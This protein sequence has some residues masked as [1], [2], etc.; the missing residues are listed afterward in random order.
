[1]AASQ[2]DQQPPATDD[3]GQDDDRPEWA[4]DLKSEILDAVK[5]MLGSA[6]G[7]ERA[8]LTD[9]DRSRAERAEHLVPDLDRMIADA[10]AVNDKAKTEAADRETTGKRLDALEAARPET[11]PIQRG[12]LHRAMRW[13]EPPE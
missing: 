9:P 12:P 10:I 2:T 13:G 8:N 5:G 7:R 1:M 6:R 4:E 11:T 3:P